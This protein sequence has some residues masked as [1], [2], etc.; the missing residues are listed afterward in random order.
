M[1]S[2]R[3]D[4]YKK[5]GTFWMDSFAPLSIPSHLIHQL[6]LCGALIAC[7]IMNWG[8]GDGMRCVAL[9]CT[10]PVDTPTLW[11]DDPFRL[12]SLA[13]FSTALTNL[14]VPKEANRPALA[15]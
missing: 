7:G 5:C 3:P 10:G 6:D 8:A 9:R 2:C 11:G 13:D 15:R 14:K 12:G 1:I 4:N